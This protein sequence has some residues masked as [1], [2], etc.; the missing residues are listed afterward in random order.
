[1]DAKQT[2]L[3]IV[4]VLVFIAFQAGV[5]NALGPVAWLLGVII[6]AVILNLIGRVAMPRRQPP[7]IEELWK[8]TVIFAIVVT[9]IYS[10]GAPLL[11]SM[12]PPPAGMSMAQLTAVFLA[13]WL[14][15]FGAAMFVT[16]WTVKWGVTT[17][18][19]ILWAFG[20]IILAMSEGN[21]FDFGI[22]TGVPFVIYGL[23]TK[24]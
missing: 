2:G 19:G 6:F 18:V 8:Y 1:M 21:Y 9:A 13:F 5:F 17:A 22:L 14:V 12:M 4:Q 10:L 24:G 7:M 16:G 3:G 15:I 23:I 11:P 20:G